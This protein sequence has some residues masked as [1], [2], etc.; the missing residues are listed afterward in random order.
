MNTKKFSM[1]RPT[2][3]TTAI[4]FLAA[5]S[6]MPGQQATVLPADHPEVYYSYFFFMENFGNWLDATAAQ[7]PG[8]QAKL[9]ASA[10]RYLKIDVSELPKLIATCRLVTASL[11]QV[12]SDNRQMSATASAGGQARNVPI[13]QAL[14]A[15][16]E[17]AIMEGVAQLQRALSAASWNAVQA[18][19]NGAHRAAIGTAH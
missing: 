12:A 15:K 1:R 10:A 13:S 5:A 16:R 17:A 3:A 9:M 11:R 8:E 14:A 7:T 2:I 19:M 6:T 4:L 18:H